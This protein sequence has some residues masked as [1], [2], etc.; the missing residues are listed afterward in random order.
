[1]T[2]SRTKGHSFER[3][4]ARLLR[5]ELGDIV[6]TDIKRILDQTRESELGDIEIHDFVVECKR[7]APQAS[8]A[9]AWWDQVWAAATKSG[10]HPLLVYKFDRVPIRCVVPFYLLNPDYPK[11]REYRAEMDFENMA[12]IMRE[13]INGEDPFI[14]SPA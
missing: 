9:E 4:V 12:M 6:D 5:D 11:K 1:M 3:D 2:N 10:K 7:Y 14:F 13:Y 8:P